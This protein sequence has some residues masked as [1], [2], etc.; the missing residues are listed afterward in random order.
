MVHIWDLWFPEAGATGVSFA[1]GRLDRTDLVWVHA[2][3]PVLD[4]EVRTLG[5]ER[6]AHGADLRR[7][8]DSPVALLRLD[9]TSVVR[10]DRWPVADDLGSP[11]ILPGGEVGI[12]RCRGC[13]LWARATQT[14][15]GE[16]SAH[17]PL[18]LVGEL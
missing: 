4:V 5:G 17:R 8:A 7:T 1:R 3:P 18:A 6:V 15:F 11:V 9:G 2:A 13:G 12:L 10:D 14:V 16:G